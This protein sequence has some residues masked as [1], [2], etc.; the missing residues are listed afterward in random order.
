MSIANHWTDEKVERVVG[1]ILQVGVLAS[2]LVV[3]TGG[4]LYL[5]EHV[6]MP[7]SHHQFHGEPEELRT[8]HGI[9]GAAARLDSRGLIQ[10]GVLLLILTPIVRVAFTVLVFVVQRDYVFVAV[11]LLVLGILLFSLLGARLLPG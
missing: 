6:G 11:T 7:A 1:R 9:A 2:A 5:V 3:L 4:V 8:L 10:F